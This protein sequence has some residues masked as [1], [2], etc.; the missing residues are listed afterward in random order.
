MSGEG[1]SFF[2]RMKAGTVP[3]LILLSVTASG[4]GTLTTWLN[5]REYS[6][7][8]EKCEE[9]FEADAARQRCKDRCY[10]KFDWSESPLLDH[11]P[12]LDNRSRE[13]REA[14]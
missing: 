11:M 4:C 1:F 3:I 14:N 13:K 6:R 9:K 2:N 7:C 12:N 8:L 5:Y 10:S